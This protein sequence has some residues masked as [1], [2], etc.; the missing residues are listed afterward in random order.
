[1]KYRVVPFSPSMDTRDASSN[2]VAQFQEVID[3]NARDGWE[4]VSLED[5]EFDELTPGNAGC[6]GIGRTPPTVNTRRIYL[7]VFRK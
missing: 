2:P 5:I 7:V 1:M 4:Y 3:E 6:F